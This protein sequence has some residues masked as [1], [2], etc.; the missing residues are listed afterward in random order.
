MAAAAAAAGAGSANDQLLSNMAFADGNHDFAKKQAGPNK[1]VGVFN[2]AVLVNK[3]DNLSEEGCMNTVGGNAGFK[4]Q[5]L[6]LAN[7]ATMSFR[8]ITGVEFYI[9]AVDL[10]EADVGEQ[11]V[12][13]CAIDNAV[14][15]VDTVSLQL[16]E[17]LSQGPKSAIRVGYA[18]TP[19]SE[20][21][22]ASKV[23]PSDPMFR[24]SD[25][26]GVRLSSHTQ[27]SG[28]IVYPGRIPFNPATPTSNFHSKYTFTLSKLRNY[29]FM[30]KIWHRAV[31]VTVSSGAS[32]QESPDAKAANSIASLLNSVLASALKKAAKL[33]AGE[34]FSVNAAWARKRSGDWLQV[35]S[36]LSLLLQSFDPPLPTDMR[37]YFV[38]Y[39]YIALSYA[40]AMGVDTIFFPAPTKEHPNPARILVFSTRQFPGVDPAVEEAKRAAEVAAIAAK[41]AAK[42]AACTSTVTKERVSAIL[43]FAD[44]FKVNIEAAK[45]A[46]LGTIQ[47]G[48]FKG[49]PP[50]QF[51]AAVQ[52]GLHYAHTS[53]ETD[54]DDIL[55]DFEPLRAWAADPAAAWPADQ[56][57][58]E[59]A[60][61]VEVTEADMLK[62]NN[63]AKL[64]NNFVTQFNKRQEIQHLDKWFTQATASAFSRRIATL[65]ANKSVDKD[66]YSFLAYIARVD[67]T[68]PIREVLLTWARTKGKPAADGMADGPAKRAVLDLYRAMEQYL[69]TSPGDAPAM[70]NTADA[71]E[72]VAAVVS[73]IQDNEAVESTEVIDLADNTED[74]LVHSGGR[75]RTFRRGGWK[76]DRAA[77]RFA[78]LPNI[79]A[80]YPLL[81][82]HIA[83][84]RP[85]AGAVVVVARNEA[86]EA[87]A[88]QVRQPG[89]PSAA[90]LTATAAAA[91][92]KYPDTAAQV[93]GG[94]ASQADLL[95]VYVMLEALAT[96]VGPDLDNSPDLFLYER[97]FAFLKIA[98]E[99]E[100]LGYMMREVLITMVRTST[101]RPIVEKA[102]G[103]S[104]SF[105]LLCSALAGHV[106]GEIDGLDEA[107]G[108]ALLTDPKNMATLQGM[109]SDAA[110]QAQPI[111]TED[112]QTLKAEVAKK[113]VAAG[114]P[115]EVAPAEAPPAPAPAPVVETA[116]DLFVW[117]VGT[118]ADEQVPGWRPSPPEKEEDLP[119]T[120]L[121]TPIPGG[122]RRR[123]RSRRNTR[124]FLP[125]DR[126]RTHHHI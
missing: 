34:I 95:P 9:K 99:A 38:S 37:P 17:R 36:C 1:A 84:Q 120:A 114:P 24:P 98:S 25:T 86:R 109:Y 108:L 59:K 81:A 50:Q 89:M 101:G 42:I 8:T 115:A 47:G 71:P 5:V 68:S 13:R 122:R 51:Q 92:E 28:P 11:L 19:E 106:C 94:G 53:F 85:V 90:V 70:K 65:I 2:Q 57:I 97:L 126:Y 69:D 12:T 4:D 93:G 26:T 110:D 35:L 7:D 31:N 54:A 105:S 76:E 87:G 56:D 88:P 79:L 14:L 119:D 16:F 52:Q 66:I 21:D 32:V 40:L 10:T 60:F 18:Y 112:V 33:T 15:V 27:T 107:P 22:P 102:L 75:R 64:P 20:N 55:L 41:K 23:A 125:H 62:H 103:S 123:R 117:P 39:D 61:A 3:S 6:G 111:T 104:M 45:S 113:I 67:R 43:D 100:G 77:R 58:C 80:L 48:A 30:K 46:Y 44:T 73:A 96:Q 49:G 83:A 72:S 78:V 124:S 82:G 63:E 91:K 118:T 116:D 74:P 29:G 121:N